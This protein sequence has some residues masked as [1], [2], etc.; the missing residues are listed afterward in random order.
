[1]DGA[2]WRAD[3]RVVENGFPREVRLRSED[4]RVDLDFNRA[5][6]PPCAFTD[7]ATCPLPPAKNRL[8]LSVMA[9]ELDHKH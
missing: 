5:K 7:F 2:G 1:M 6:N 4:G 3:Y 8:T 9:G